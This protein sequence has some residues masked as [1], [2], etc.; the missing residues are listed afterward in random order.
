MFTVHFFKE[1]LSA[2]EFV[3]G[4]HVFIRPVRQIAIFLEKVMIIFRKKQLF[5]NMKWRR[6]IRVFTDFASVGDTPT[7]RQEDLSRDQSE[8]S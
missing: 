6:Q 7:K 3:I 8:R 1:K 5:H 4:A 2:V